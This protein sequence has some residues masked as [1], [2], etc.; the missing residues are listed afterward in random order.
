MASRTQQY[1][2]SEGKEHERF[3]EDTASWASTKSRCASAFRAQYVWIITTFAVFI[4]AHL[5]ALTP[6]WSTENILVV[7]FNYGPAVAI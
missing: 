6:P 5:H 2:E 4:I 3:I 1:F 7:T